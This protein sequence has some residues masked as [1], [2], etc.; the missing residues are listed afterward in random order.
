EHHDVAGDIREG[1]V[2]VVAEEAI[3]LGRRVPG[4]GTKVEVAVE[5]VIAEAAAVSARDELA[6]DVHP[7]LLGDVGEGP[8]AVVA[9]ELVLADLALVVVAVAEAGDVD[10]DPAVVVVVTR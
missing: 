8:V 3:A 6:G 9:V 4:G 7:G 5:V 1:A 10:V 2:T